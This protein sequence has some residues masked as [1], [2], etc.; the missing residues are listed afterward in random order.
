MRVDPGEPA[1]RRRGPP[2][3]H[4]LPQDRALPEHGGASG[5]EPGVP[6]HEGPSLIIIIVITSIITITITIMCFS[7]SLLLLLLVPG[8]EGPRAGGACGHFS[9]PAFMRWTR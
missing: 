8:H 6:D 1:L 4:G 2:D 9:H 5:G 3:S 7:Y